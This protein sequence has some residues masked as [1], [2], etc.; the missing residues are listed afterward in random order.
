MERILATGST[1]WTSQQSLSIRR[2]LQEWPL[3]LNLH[4]NQVQPVIQ[5][6]TQLETEDRLDSGTSIEIQNRLNQLAHLDR[7]SDPQI[8]LIVKSILDSTGKR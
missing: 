7:Y 3:K 8:Q 4:H 1:K 5:H 2:H 6:L